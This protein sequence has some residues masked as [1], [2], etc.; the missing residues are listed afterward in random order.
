MRN[1]LWLVLWVTALRG[2]TPQAGCDLVRALELHRT[3]DFANAALAYQACV[4]ADPRAETRSNLGAVLVRLGRFQEAIDQYQ[5]ALRAAPVQIVPQLRFNLVLAYYKSA[6]IAEAA[7]E[8][9]KLRASGAESPNILLLLADCR[10]RLGEYKS[11]IEVARPLE[12]SEPGPGVDYV[13]GMALIRDGQ[14]AEGQI[15]V[16]RLL[17]RGE[18]AEGDLLVGTAQFTAGDYPA[19]IREFAKAEKLNPGLPSLHSYYGR[20]LL[21]TGDPD[22]AESQFRKELAAYPNDYDANFQLAAIL[23][24]R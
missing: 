9:Q 23:A 12:T 8:L 2:Q 1:R 17:G 4:D 24:H 10:L 15:R 7:A 21:F 3:G 22:G 6:Q 19:A 11:A 18:S 5:A 14:I 20:A 13:L 16:E